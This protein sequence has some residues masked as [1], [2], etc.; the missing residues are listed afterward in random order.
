V[1]PSRK[2]SDEQT[3]HIVKLYVEGAS[4]NSIAV[5]LRI[6]VTTIRRTL[7]RAGV[8]M[9]SDTRVRLPDA[10]KA[11]VA[12]ICASGASI[13]QAATLHGVSTQTVTRIL[14]QH[15]VSLSTG[16][17][18]SCELDHTAFDE[19]TPESAYWMGFLFADGCNRNDGEGA[20]VVAMQLGIV[21][22]EHVEKF[23]AFLGSTHTISIRPPGRTSFGGPTAAFRVRSKRLAAALRDRGMVTKRTRAPVP[24]LIASR[25][26]WRGA[27]DGDGG[28]GVGAVGNILYPN[29][30]LTGQAILLEAF[31]TFLR[32]SALALLNQGRTA[33]GVFRVETTG[34]TAYAIIKHL[35]KDATTAL[36]RKRERARLILSGHLSQVR[37]YEK[38]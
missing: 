10:E 11:V 2:V 4:A 29:I 19:I 27:V 28:L 34:S 3:A 16:R 17:R 7:G 21:D 9:R 22:R 33:S 1:G 8:V 12:G 35:Y 24:E 6:P 26:F 15:N 38:E 37:P 18:P 31:Q 20:N 13:E 30:F 36:D 5:N 14:R 32:N 23:R 25:D